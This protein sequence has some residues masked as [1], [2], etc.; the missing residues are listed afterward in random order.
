M[1]GIVI[2]RSADAP[3]PA[4]PATL[5]AFSGYVRAAVATGYAPATFVGAA[6][7]IPATRYATDVFARAKFKVAATTD[8]DIGQFGA[9][10]E[11]RTGNG[12]GAA[13]T[14]ESFGAYNGGQDLIQSDG[15]L[16][17]WKF[18]PELALNFGLGSTIQKGSL[19]KTLYSFDAI[20]INQYTSNWGAVSN[21]PRNGNPLINSSSNSVS[22]MSLVYNS[23]PV[24]FGIGLED[25][26]NFGDNSALGV[27]GKASY[28]SSI[29]GADLSG[30]YW[31][32]PANSQAAYNITGGVGATFDPLKV[33]V[34]YGIGNSGSYVNANGT[35]NANGN[36][37][38]AFVYSVGSAYA[39]LT[40]TPQFVVELGAVRDFGS[41]GSDIFNG[42]TLVQAGAYYKPKKQ[43]T[44]GLEGQYQTGGT[45]ATNA[46]GNLGDG[47]Y[48]ADAVVRVDF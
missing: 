13:R 48:T 2:T 15:F 38:G 47:G 21:N 44:L 29:F 34:S 41:A 14:A 3:A 45:N 46:G 7:G 23:G 43:F 33:G 1:H 5:I 9:V 36:G 22:Q 12:V 40:L 8:T 31:A 35:V 10:L 18:T 27:T 17:F 24:G 28:K 39:I 20:S 37:T 42:A 16:G 4:A 19:S 30:G 26:D 11:F 32:S 6:P 25:A